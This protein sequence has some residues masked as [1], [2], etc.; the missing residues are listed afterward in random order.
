MV[1]LVIVA[2]LIAGMVLALI[3]AACV[4]AFGFDAVM[5][6]ALEPEDDPWPDT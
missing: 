3:A 4:V 1:T 6:G 2:L 5:H